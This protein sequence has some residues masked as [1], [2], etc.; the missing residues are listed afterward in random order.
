MFNIPFTPDRAYLVTE[1]FDHCMPAG[2]TE[3]LNEHHGN[4]QLAQTDYF[5]R[6]RGFLVTFMTDD[7]QIE[8]LFRLKFG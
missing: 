3:F 5:Y 7:P 1:I 6:Q 8:T 2:I 4:I